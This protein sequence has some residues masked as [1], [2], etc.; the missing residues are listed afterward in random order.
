M[1]FQNKRSIFQLN[2]NLSIDSSNEFVESHCSESA[3]NSEDFI[4]QIQHSTT[5]NTE[6]DQQISDSSTP[7]K[8]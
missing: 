5:D 7:H 4:Q 1:E 2:L 6:K 3:H 8:V